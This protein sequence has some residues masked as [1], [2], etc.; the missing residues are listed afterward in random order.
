M[1]LLNGLTALNRL[2]DIVDEIMEEE[3]AASEEAEA[4]AEDVLEE[5]AEETPIEPSEFE[6]EL[7]N[8]LPTAENTTKVR[9][10]IPAW[11][12]SVIASAVTCI[13]ILTVY[14][15]IVMP[16]LRPRAV[17]SYSGAEKQ[18]V[19]PDDS[20]NPV[21]KIADSVVTITGTTSYHSF[22]GI[23]SSKTTCSGVVLSDDG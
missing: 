2:I 1:P 6:R 19:I 9:Q 13:L 16:N 10:P 3:V 18:E 8:Y 20:K 23:S 17:I 5:V 21:E 15:A 11:V 14:S 12:Y 22:F 7:E 4:D